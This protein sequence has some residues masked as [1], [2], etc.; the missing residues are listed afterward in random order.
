VAGIA[1]ITPIVGR[2]VCILTLL[3]A[4]SAQAAD[5]ALGA[6]MIVS[7]GDRIKGSD[8][9]GHFRYA[10]D[11]QYRWLDRAGGV[12]QYVLRPALGYDLRP[13]L[14]IWFGYVYLHAERRGSSTVAEQRLW[15]QIAWQFAATDN[16][17][18]LL[19]GRLEERQFDFADDTGL[20]L[21]LMLRGRFPDALRP[22][23]GV[24]LWIEPFFDLQET[25][26]GADP[27]LAQFRAAIGLE[28]ALH[29]KIELESG[30]MNQYVPRSEQP[31]FA[32]H[33]LYANFRIRF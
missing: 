11:A 12:E 22:G 3:F 8:G 9:T 31:D 20:T 32:N 2:L 23:L 15:Q 33:L 14:S 13:D 24:L 6:W 19:R 21:R 27:G 1:R 30:Y 4:S 7:T 16:S 26:W 5:D 28:F 25:D 29:P 10:F 18:W 17:S